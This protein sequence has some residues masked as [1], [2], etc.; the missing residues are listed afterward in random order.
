M[1]RFPVFSA[2]FLTCFVL[3]GHAARAESIATVEAVNGT[4]HVSRAAGNPLIVAAGSLVEK[5][6][7]LTTATDSSARLRFTDGAE[8]AIRPASSLVISNYHFQPLAPNQDT[9]VMRLLRGGIRNLT[10]LIGKRSTRHAYRLD[11]ATATIGIRGTD[12]TARICETDCAEEMRSAAQKKKIVAPPSQNPIVA[13]LFRAE[14]KTTVTALD[15]K[16][17]PLAAGDPIYN[18]DTIESDPR[19]FATLIF[20]DDTRVVVNPGGKYMVSDYRYNAKAPEKGRML[21]ELLKGGMR[22]ATGLLGKSKPLVVRYNT[23]T[24]TIGIRGTQFD[25]W[26]APTGSNKMVGY[27]PLTVEAMSC[28]QALYAR[29]RDGTIEV[30]SGQHSLLVPKERTAYVDAPGAAPVLLDDT[31]E[32]MRTIP[33]PLPELQNADFTELFGRDG[34]TMSEPGLYVDV[35]EGRVAITQH[36]GDEIEI[37]AGET[38]FSDPEEDRLFRMGSRPW[39]IEYDKYLNDLDIDP[40]SC[41]MD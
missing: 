41:R 15:G 24:A 27:S 35:R 13:R 37:N 23:V 25:L 34:S 32:F 16:K 4:V 21:T 38:G 17:R 14:G 36:D 26:C 10:G 2:L 29:T 11:T 20:T 33:L 40:L 22:V 3:A 9:L 19:G 31:P 28:D 12:F 1:G 39:F 5:G 6:D 30:T 18:W 8:L 7:T